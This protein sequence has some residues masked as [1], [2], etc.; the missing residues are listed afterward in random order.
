LTLWE[1]VRVAFTDS[2][3]FEVWFT[4]EA[5]DEAARM[6]RGWTYWPAFVFKN[7]YGIGLMALLLVGGCWGLVKSLF[8]PTPDLPH[9]A[10]GLLLMVIPIGVFWWSRSR[11]IRTATE[12]LA[13]INPL[14]LTFDANGLHTLEKSGAHNF[15]PWPGYDGFREGKKV[16]LLRETE[17][18]QYRVVGKETV[19]AEAVE[20]LRSAIRSRLPE[21][22]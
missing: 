9:A 6:S 4:I 21:I 22:Q 16:M 17:T 19:P 8:A 12:M 13:R 20:Q 5:T 2:M 11:D 7:L 1:S 15:I 10:G 14:I 3:K 18:Q